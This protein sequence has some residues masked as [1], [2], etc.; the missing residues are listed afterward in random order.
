MQ[1]QLFRAVSAVAVSLAMTACAS[2]AT[3]VQWNFN[4]QT[5]PT[6]PSTGVGTIARTPGTGAFA[7]GFTPSQLGSPGDPNPVLIGSTLSNNAVARASAPSLTA[8]GTWG[9]DVKTSTVGFGSPKI[10]WHLLG[11]FRTSRY[12]QV[13]ATIDGVNYA[14]VPVGIGS[15]A[16]NLGSATL[17]TNGQPQ[18]T[19]SAGVS[20]SGLVTVITSDNMIPTA[21]T[22]AAFIYEL[23]Y[24]FPAGTVYENNPNFGV[25]IAQVFGPGNTDYVSSFAGTTIADTTKGYTVTTNAGGGSLRYDMVTVSASVPEPTMLSGV[26]LAAVGLLGRRRPR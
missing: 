23:S 19:Q 26:G 8:S 13:F 11:G 15:T 12:Y 7:V 18:T 21:S 9:I 16:A 5:S 22:G 10:S 25:R 17:A 14:P 2:A 6:N 1:T 24:T 4:Q 3:L 20:N